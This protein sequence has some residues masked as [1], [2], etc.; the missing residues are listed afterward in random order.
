MKVVVI[1]VMMTTLIRKSEESG[2]DRS[3]DDHFQRTI[4]QKWSSYK[5][6]PTTFLNYHQV[7][8]FLPK[9]VMIKITAANA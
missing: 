8:L 9:I 7:R 4:Q 3:D 1:E 5:P 6:N 2:R